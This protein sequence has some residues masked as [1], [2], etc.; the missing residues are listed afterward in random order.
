MYFVMKTFWWLLINWGC[1]VLWDVICEVVWLRLPCFFFVLFSTEH[2]PGPWSLVWCLGVLSSCDVTT[3][4]D[5]YN[6]KAGPSHGR[7]SPNISKKENE[8]KLTGSKSFQGTSSQNENSS[9]SLSVPQKISRSTSPFS[10]CRARRRLK[11]TISFCLRKAVSWNL[12]HKVKRDTLKL[13][14][15]IYGI[16]KPNKKL[17]VNYFRP[18]YLLSLTL[19]IKYPSLLYGLGWN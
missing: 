15:L 11:N 13:I 2:A 14:F 8:K 6:L 12:G 16:T 3:L 18:K 1:D 19:F 7:L 9:Q 17:V 10:F 4:M 5:G